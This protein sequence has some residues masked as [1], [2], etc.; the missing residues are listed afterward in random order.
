MDWECSTVGRYGELDETNANGKSRLD[1][2]TLLRQ[3]ALDIALRVAFSHIVALVPQV[4]AF[5]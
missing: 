3:R 4:L 5:G 1:D 2:R